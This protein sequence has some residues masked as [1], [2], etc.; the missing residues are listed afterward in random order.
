MKSPFE[1]AGQLITTK[2]KTGLLEIMHIFQDKG[3]S[4]MIIY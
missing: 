4:N 1:S 3:A 2:S